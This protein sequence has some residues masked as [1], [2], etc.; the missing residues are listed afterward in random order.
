EGELIA[1]GAE[2]RWGDP[3]GLTA[4]RKLPAGQG[5]TQTSL[6]KAPRLCI[7]KEDL[8]KHFF[9]ERGSVALVGHAL[10]GGVALEQANRQA[11]DGRQVGGRVAVGHP[12]G[13]FAKGDIELP[14]QVV[15]DAP[16]AA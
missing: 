12:A 6:R 2:R 7:N 16:M 3:S 15:L 9:V 1:A 10:L 14:V 5:Q 8:F 11:A 4:G 13:V